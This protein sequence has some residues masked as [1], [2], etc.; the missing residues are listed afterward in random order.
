MKKRL[1]AFALLLTAM[2][3]LGAAPASAAPPKTLPAETQAQMASDGLAC[4]YVAN[5]DNTI[6]SKT[7]APEKAGMARWTYCYPP[8]VPG[9]IVFFDNQGW[10]GDSV[11]MNRPAAGQCRYMGAWDNWAGSMG[12][13]TDYGVTL[14]QSGTCTGTLTTVLSHIY[15]PDLYVYGLGNAVST[16]ARP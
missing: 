14:W 11:A 16:I 13:Y 15:E 8:S 6:A 1:A 3:G 2:V 5:D 12:N 9:K 7:C 4:A 10:C